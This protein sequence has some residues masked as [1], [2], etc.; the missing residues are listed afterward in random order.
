MRGFKSG[1]S[2]VESVDTT[3]ADSEQIAQDAVEM[4][5]EAALETALD[6]MPVD[7]MET[8]VQI[9]VSVVEQTQ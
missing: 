6:N 9:T 4:A 7:L 2:G 5:T 1:G 3:D 8:D